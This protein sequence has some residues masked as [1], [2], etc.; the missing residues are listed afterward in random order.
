MDFTY[1]P[2]QEK[3]R[4]EL[5]AWLEKNSA[6]MLGRKDEILHNIIGERVLKLPKG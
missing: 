1:T 4:G 2:A 3:F 6:D 5:C